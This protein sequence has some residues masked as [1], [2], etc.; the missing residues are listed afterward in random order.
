MRKILCIVFFLLAIFPLF[1]IYAHSSDFIVK[2]D[3][4]VFLENMSDKVVRVEETL[5]IQAQNPRYYIP[6]G[7]TQTITISNLSLRESQENIERKK[8][9]IKV[10]D[11]MNR[12]LQYEIKEEGQRLIINIKTLVDVSPGQPFVAKVEY[13]T[14]ELINHSGNITNIYLP[15]L[16]EDTIFEDIDGR[17]NLK[18][19]YQYTLTYHLPLNAP[20]PS[21]KFPDSIYAEKTQRNTNYIFPQKDRINNTGWLQLGDE[22]FFFFK[23]T[24]E[25]PKTDTFT[26]TRLNKYT[27][28]IS[29]NILEIALPKQ[30]EETNQK[31]YITSI[32]PDV[33]SIRVDDEENIIAVFEP[34]ANED[35]LIEI[36]GYITL[37]REQREIPNM[38]L[39]EYYERIQHLNRLPTYTQADKFWESDNVAIQQVAKKIL[40]QKKESG[41]LDLVRANYDFVID[42]LDYSQE[43]AEGENIRVGALKALLGEPAVCMEYADLLVAILRAQKI[44]AKVAIGYGNDPN[45]RRDLEDE[46][47]STGHQWVQVWIPDYGW[48][49]VDPT[50]GETKREYIGG[51]LDHVLWYTIANSSEKISDTM[52]YSAD[53][54]DESI[55]EKYEVIIKPIH[56][57][58]FPILGETHSLDNF[59]LKYESDPS[60]ETYLENILKTTTLGRTVIFLIPILG[61]LVLTI[62]LS[63]IVSRFFKSKHI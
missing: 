50:W 26:P 23:I 28:W 8:N 40:D 62:T 56:E 33:K 46:V 59:I 63:I 25:L 21:F 11:Q 60:D 61:F 55:F 6:A 54:V 7:S 51:N 39:D 1:S 44:P 14:N 57:D 36:E 3:F 42:T 32:T 58:E 31:V 24:Q 16:H 52:L 43:K 47:I 48:L 18:T 35:Q 22:Q 5:S 2:S 13:K 30:F 49:T 19:I 37:R 34:R 53:I 41:I 45:V 38:K 10:V 17:N 9:S 20:Q 27:N 15:G 12:P 4:D 29:R